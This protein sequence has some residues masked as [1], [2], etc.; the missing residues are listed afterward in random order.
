LAAPP[1]EKESRFI[2]RWLAAHPLAR[3]IPISKDSRKVHMD[4]PPVHSTYIWIED[5]KDSLNLYLIREGFY[6]A[7]SMTDMVDSAKRFEEMLSDPRLTSGREEIDKEG[8]EEDAP[9]RLVSQSDYA[10]RMRRAEGAEQEA[11]R[12]RRGLWSD[13]GMKH[14][15][16]PS[17][18]H[19]LE[20]YTRHKQWFKRVESLVASD[21]RLAQIGRDPES[22]RRA[23]GAGVSREKVNEYV[24]LLERLDANETLSGVYGLGRVCLITADIV[25][26]AF[27]TGIIK[28]Y[29]LS[30]SDPHPLVED[31]EDWPPA[32]ADATTAYKRLADGWYLFELHH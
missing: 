10:E 12:A 21:E 29:V 25:Y 7:H 16:P 20:E 19:M 32:F 9:Q 14:W 18:A 5:A 31:L 22:V 27:D 2:A 8:A 13:A 1:A 15:N 26:G 11:K 17:D 6:Q 24:H 30:P 23:L 4:L 28:G 3:A